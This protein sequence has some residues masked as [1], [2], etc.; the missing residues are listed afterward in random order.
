MKVP[1]MKTSNNRR[2]MDLL[3]FSRLM[4]H[5]Q[6]PCIISHLSGSFAMLLFSRFG[7]GKPSLPS[8]VMLHLSEALAL[9]E[10]REPQIEVADI[11]ILRNFSEESCITS[12]PCSKT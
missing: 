11:R 3:S 2:M 8:F 10:I 9:T 12:L 7:S 1:A 6:D 5:A 4:Q